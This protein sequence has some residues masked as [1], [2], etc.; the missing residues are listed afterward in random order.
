MGNAFVSVGV[1]VVSGVFIKYGAER[2]KLIYLGAGIT[3][4]AYGNIGG[5]PILRGAVG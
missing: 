3:V 2:S 4:F 1:G 5:G